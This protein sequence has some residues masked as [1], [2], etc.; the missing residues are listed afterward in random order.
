MS[1]KYC[2]V[3]TW[4]KLKKRI[5]GRNIKLTESIFPIYSNAIETQINM[6]Q[7]AIN[8]NELVN[9][10]DFKIFQILLFDFNV[11]HNVKIPIFL[12]LT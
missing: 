7:Y 8:S 5:Y 9:L 1:Q 2:L 10:V 6:L 11:I 4:E 12:E 3:C